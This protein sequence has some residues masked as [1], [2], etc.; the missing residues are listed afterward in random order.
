VEVF[1]GDITRRG[2]FGSVKDLVGGIR[3]FIDGWN[4][5]CHPFVW[6]KSPDDVLEHARPRKR[7]SDE[8]ALAQ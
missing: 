2:E 4:E 7:T 8:G 3:L 1:F 5:L 6:T